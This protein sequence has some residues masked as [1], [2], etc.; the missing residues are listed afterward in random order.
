MNLNE[1]SKRPVDAQRLRFLPVITLAVG[2]LVGGCPSRDNGSTTSSISTRAAFP[3]A[4]VTTQRIAENAGSNGL[5]AASGQAHDPAHPPI[6]CPLRK[7][8]IDPAHLRP[9]EDVEQYIAFLERTDRT[10]WQKPD[11]VVAVLQLGGAETVVDLGAGSGYFTFRLARAL[12]QG[13]V[14]AVDTEAEM[15]RHIHH[16]A[17]TER[18]RNVQA[19]LVRPDDPKIPTEADLVFVC[20]VLHH[21]PDRAAWLAKIAVQMKPGARL[22]LIEFKEG[23]LPEG[24]P[25]SVKISRAQMVE[26][27]AKAGLSLESEHPMLLP[28]QTFLVFRKAP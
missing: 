25:E 26:L 28:Y 15:I 5:Q 21:V 23:N 6:D 14:I 8:G 17:M 7:Q 16:K 1:S 10:A 9:F 19:E 22:V 11:E 4:S 3:T 20:D 18:F 27:A 2:I 13:K 24:P 12:P